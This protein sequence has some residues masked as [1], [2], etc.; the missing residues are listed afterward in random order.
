MLSNPEDPLTHPLTHTQLVRPKL[1]DQ[2]KEELQVV[3]KSVL[4]V[5]C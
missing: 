2:Q 3:F 1:S 4:V 5:G